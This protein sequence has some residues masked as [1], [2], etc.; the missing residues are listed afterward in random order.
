MLPLGL[1]MWDKCLYTG[2]CL[3]SWMPQ[4]EMQQG[5]DCFHPK[6]ASGSV[7]FEDLQQIYCVL[8]TCTRRR[9]INQEMPSRMVPNFTRLKGATPVKNNFA[10]MPRVSHLISALVHILRISVVAQASIFSVPSTSRCDRKS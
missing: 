5:Q 3:A 2:M 6:S 10:F 9:V 1:A 4:K 8:P 7:V